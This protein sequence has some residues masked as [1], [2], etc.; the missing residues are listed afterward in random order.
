M[1]SDLGACL[2]AQGRLAEAEPLLVRGYE[3]GRAAQG[4]YRADAERA[5]R[6]LVAHYERAGRPD[7]AARWLAQRR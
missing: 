6:S 7:A 1:E 3:E 5:L 2:S 4:V